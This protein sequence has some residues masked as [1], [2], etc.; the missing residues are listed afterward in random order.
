MLATL[1]LPLEPFVAS[2]ENF[3][4]LAAV[5]QSLHAR[6]VFHGAL[7]DEAS[8]SVVKLA[9]PE[10]MFYAFGTK[11]DLQF[12]FWSRHV[13]VAS[14]FAAPSHGKSPKADLDAMVVL[15]GAGVVEKGE[16]PTTVN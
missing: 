4:Q 3:V 13:V 14:N 7:G 11:P 15:A 5:V 9:K 6:R 2:W 10:P 16:A 12:A 8:V 1:D